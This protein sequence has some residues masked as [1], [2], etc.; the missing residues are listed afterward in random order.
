MGDQTTV[1]YKVY[2]YKDWAKE[3]AL[4]VRRVG[5]DREVSTSFTYLKEKL[6][7]V[8]PV[9]GRAKTKST[10][11]W[12]DEENE[13]ITIRSDEELVIALTEMPGPVYK[14][15]VQFTNDDTDTK[16]ASLFD[17]MDEC[18]IKDGH[19]Q[20]EGV[21]HPG[22][23][24][25][26]C[27]QPVVGFRYKCVQCPD[28]DLC[29]R[30]E[31]KKIHPGHNMMRISAPDG[32]WPQHFFRRLN[33]MHDR[34]NKR[35]ASASSAA[36]PR[37]EE[38]EF[39]AED[40]PRVP[41]FGCRRGR[42][43]NRGGQGSRGRFSHGG[44][45]NANAFPPGCGQKW[46]DAM[47]KGWA[48]EGQFQGPNFDPSNPAH[49]ATSAHDAAQQ[50]ARA[51]AS[52]AAASHAA[53][54]SKSAFTAAE[55]TSATQD[56][57]N[58]QEQ[59]TQQQQAA[60]PPR[61]QSLDQIFQGNTEFLA[62]VGNM[63]AAALDPF[64][65]NV[66]IDVETPNGQRTACNTAS[67]N[68]A[69]NGQANESLGG[70]NLDEKIEEASGE[71][72]FVGNDETKEVTEK[73]EDDTASATAEKQESEDDEFEIVNKSPE[74]NS[75]TPPIAQEINIPIQVEQKSETPV[76]GNDNIEKGEPS[77]GAQRHE[78]EGARNVPITLSNHPAKV[79]YAAPN[80]GPL[81]PE[82]PENETTPAVAANTNSAQA[83][84]P[85][86]EENAER[87]NDEV[88]VAKHKDPRI[89]VALQAMLNMGFTNEGGWLTQLLEA[90]EGDIGKTLDVLQPVN[91]KSTRK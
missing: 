38:S 36:E 44:M 60:G 7:S 73:E 5:I 31:A 70:N 11:T 6:A 75:P 53:S 52:V 23:T 61:S 29:G 63:V 68:S 3:Q 74:A 79:L 87:K 90:K 84:A 34:I 55:G 85:S 49:M 91:P 32:V 80:G 69:P 16:S 48:G 30:C 76:T 10:I 19:E 65:I 88:G 78:N 57:T 20:Q 46:F 17:L 15:H 89:Q 1:S 42:F 14:L 83:S 51:A 22:V 8:F 64:G 25:D 47:M 33:K 37:D 2:L 71:F 28:Y 58:R 27:D 62:N 39:F 72:G 24:C 67:T 82:L 40:L 13:W 45:G 43:T 66:Q 77:K 54:G 41:P 35:A 21:A 50:A 86:A 81:Y 18:T 56:Q 4:E 12:Q 26:G 59:S 9:L